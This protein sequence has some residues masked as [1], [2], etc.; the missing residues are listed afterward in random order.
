MKDYASLFL[1]TVGKPLRISEPLRNYSYFRI[2]GEADFFFEA[3][4]EKDLISAVR[5]ARE[6]SLRWYIIGEGSNLLF[7][8]EGFR[9]LII[10]NRVR[11]IKKRGIAE[12]EVASGTLLQELVRFCLEEGTGD[13]E[14]LTGIPG[15][16]GGAVYGN[17]G[18][19]NRDISGVFLK[20]CL[21]TESGDVKEFKRSD[22]AFE[23]R[24]SSLKGKQNIVLHAILQGKKKNKEKISSLMQKF[25]RR[26][27]KK[28]PPE[29]VACAGSYFK[30]PLSPPGEKISA[31]FLLDQINAKDLKVGD[32]EV[33]S[34]HANFIINRKKASSKDVRALAEELKSRVERKFGVVLEEE[35]IFLPAN[36]SE[37]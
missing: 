11:G 37:L 7:D 17:A 31:A 8:D 34:G 3:S 27:E 33:Y 24:F 1:N 30:N 23:Y 35:V 5:F 28:L 9:G 10:R 18:A 29:N 12:I 16:V 21:L 32:A 13:L 36:P 4:S 6:S 20:A 14:F 26:R 2:G 22:F 15:T 25:Q 19:F